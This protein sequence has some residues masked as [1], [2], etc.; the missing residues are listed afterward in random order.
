MHVSLCLDPRRPWP[1]LLTLAQAADRSGLHTAYVPD[2]FMPAGDVG[3]VPGGA[4]LEGWTALSAIAGSTRRVRLGTLVLGIAYRHPAV[5]ANMAA[6]LDHVSAGRVTLGLGAGWQPN[7]HEAFGIDLPTARVRIERLEESVQ[8]IQALLRDEVTTFEG[9]HV[10]VIG[11]RCEPKPLQDPLPVLVAGGGER[12]T[13]PV[14]ARHAQAWHTWAQPPE[15]RRKAAVLDAACAEIGRDPSE[16]LRLTGQT[17]L[18]TSRRS[19]AAEDDGDDGDDGDV[20]GSI[21]QVL[22]E[23]ARYR[24]AGVDEFIS[25]DHVEFP[26]EDAVS[27]VQCLGSDVIPHLD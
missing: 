9:V 4:I 2:H 5:V 12:R 27:S 22:T 16:V 6:T 24:D 18:V 23:L 20:V 8:V 21:D 19:T 7:E 13:I 10:H 1:D 26:L 11:A 15:F 14:A 3:D 17:V 25:R